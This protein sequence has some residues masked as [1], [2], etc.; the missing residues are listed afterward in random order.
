[1]TN[2]GGFIAARF[3]LGVGEAPLFPGGARV[4]RGERPAPDQAAGLEVGTRAE[5]LVAGAGEDDRANG[6]VRR[7]LRP[8]SGERF[9][10]IVAPRRRSANKNS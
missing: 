1:M 10:A 8:Q 7:Q 9:E 2:F 3:A 4:V 5:G 6:R